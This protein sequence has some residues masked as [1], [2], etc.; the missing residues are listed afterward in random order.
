MIQGHVRQ[1]DWTTGWIQWNDGGVM[2]NLATSTPNKHTS[3]TKQNTTHF[4]SVCVIFAGRCS[5]TLKK[6]LITSNFDFCGEVNQEMK[7]FGKNIQKSANPLFS[8]QMC[9]SEKPGHVVVPNEGAK[10]C[11][12]S[13]T[14]WGVVL[15]VVVWL[16]SYDKTME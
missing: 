9:F 12:I 16:I 4:S 11:R 5:L 2:Q 7:S 14:M 15:S 1:E 10:C 6:L 3:N 13:S 8:G